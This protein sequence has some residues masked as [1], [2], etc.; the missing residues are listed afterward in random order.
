MGYHYLKDKM[1]VMFQDYPVKKRIE[2]LSLDY[3]TKVITHHKTNQIAELT[4]SEF[5]VIENTALLGGYF[6]LRPVVYAFDLQNDKVT[7]LR[8]IY[9]NNSKL[10]EIKVNKDSVTFNV[11]VGELNKEKDQTVYVNTYDFQGNQIRD[12][13]LETKID[14]SLL[15]GVSSS[16]NDITQV[17]VGNYGYKSQT[18]PSGIYIN[19][20]NRM[21]EQNIQYINYGELDSFL[22]YLK[23]SKAIKVKA[24]ASESKAKGKEQRY[25]LLSLNRS[26]EEV[27]GKLVFLAEYFKPG[28]GN[29]VSS[30]NINGS[31][32]GNYTRNNEVDA[33]GNFVQSP[34]YDF[35][36]THA[37]VLMLDLEGNVQWDDSFDM[38]YN[39]ESRLDEHGRFQW[40]KEKELL[41]FA[42]YDDEEVIA[43]ILNGE[44]DNEVLR[45]NL[46]VKEDHNKRDELGSTVE[47]TRWYGDLFLVHGIQNVRVK[48]KS[49]VA[50][51]VFFINAIKINSDDIPKKLH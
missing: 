47:M 39:L 15:D 28:S 4:L 2:I 25:K 22:S 7:A 16:I 14:Y 9:K 24:K 45:A 36:F 13:R 50:K 19:Y 43:K 12:Y 48:D 49:E 1:F 44:N 51:R 11:L 38:D 46:K 29:R 8:G 20:V 30:Q 17:V 33:F 10:F 31:S 27:D 5:E 42:H 6:D 23:P 34:V 37:Y 32:Q 18:L 41:V 21:G 3:K 40:V 26:L 35:D